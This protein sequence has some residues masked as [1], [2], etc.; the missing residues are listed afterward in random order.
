MCNLRQ[1]QFIASEIKIITKLTHLFLTDNFKP[2][3]QTFIGDF[4]VS[5][6]IFH[7]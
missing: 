6:L 3:K 2:F 4:E 1:M 5:K 7:M